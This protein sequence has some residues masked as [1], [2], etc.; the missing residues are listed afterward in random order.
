MSA[1]YIL[2]LFLVISHHT[3]YLYKL[4]SFYVRHHLPSGNLMDTTLATYEEYTGETYYTMPAYLQEDTYI[5]T[6]ILEQ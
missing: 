6:D 4:D 5:Y 2:V 3:L 1:V